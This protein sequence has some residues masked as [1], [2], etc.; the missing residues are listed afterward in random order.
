M[1]PDFAWPSSNSFVHILFVQIRKLKWP[2]SQKVI[3]VDWLSLAASYPN[4][5]SS[6]SFSIPILLFENGYS[7]NC[8]WYKKESCSYSPNF[9]PNGGRVALIPP[10]IFVR[11]QKV[12]Q[13]VVASEIFHAFHWLRMAGWIAKLT[14]T[15][16]PTV[17]GITFAYLFSPS[18]SSHSV[19]PKPKIL[20]QSHI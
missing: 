20:F 8:W 7:P 13:E 19:C 12:S 1:V 16:C 10:A 11:Q 6:L 2:I 14:H 18:P 17:G 4:G 9:W 3:H 15:I 5:S